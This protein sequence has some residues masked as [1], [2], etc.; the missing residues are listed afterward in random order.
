MEQKDIRKI[1]FFKKI[2]YSIRNFEKYPAMSEEGA[3]KAI[4]YFSKLLII[5]SILLAI[6]TVY[7]LI[8]TINTFKG[9]IKDGS[10]NV[11]YKGNE[12]NFSANKKI[13]E[14]TP[15]GLIIID[16]ENKNDEIDTDSSNNTKIILNSETF[17]VES[18]AINNEYSYIDALQKY[19]IPEFDNETIL[20]YVS[21]PIIYIEIILLFA[22]E[23]FILYFIT[24]MIDVLTLSI[25]GVITCL[26]ARFRMKYKYI[27][28]MSIY[29]LTISIILELIYNII[30]VLTGFEM[31]YFD[32]MYTA[33]SYICLAAAIFM[34]KS[35]I[36]KQYIEM[37]KIKEE[38]R[39]EENDEKKEEDK[40]EK[41][42]E[43]KKE[44]EDKKEEGSEEETPDINSEGSNA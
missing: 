23:L 33:I 27:F 28:S 29:A 12:F 38:K 35:D 42:E 26:F 30:N 5:F 4:G 24:T 6:V 21:S 39:K 3:G 20:K 11:Y 18:S 10:I 9:Y 15:I 7:P 16:T 36:I 22:I 2:K 44:K 43:K 17:R 40:E 1:G 31:K 19:K 32:I 34:I 41:K 14:D 8:N 37:I 25:F 13:V